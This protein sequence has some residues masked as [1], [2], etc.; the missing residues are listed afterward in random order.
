MNQSTIKYVLGLDLGIASIGWS[1]MI[2][3]ETGQLTRIE[4][5]GIR[6][7]S[8]LEDGKSGK[9]ANEIRRTKRG[10]RRLRRRKHL[11]LQ[12]TKN[13]FSSSLLPDFE[14]F[15]KIDF[16][17]YL[18]PYEI[19]IKGLTEPL[20]KE[21]LSIA[22]YHYMKYR[23]FKSNR[24][25]EDKKNDGVLIKQF[26]DVEN[27]LKENNATITQL[28]YKQ[29]LEARAPE[30]RIHNVDNAGSL[31]NK[32]EQTKSIR[33]KDDKY[34]FSATR[35]MYL[36]EINL[37]LDHQ[38]SCGLI[39]TSFKEQYL[40]IFNRQRSFSMGPGKGSPYAAPE[41]MSLIS[42]MIGVCT[43]DQLPR[44][45]KASFSSESFVLLSFLN[46]L[47]FK[48]K[49][50][51]NYRG[52]TEK[53]I[54]SIYNFALKT[55]ALT[56]KNIFN[57]IN[58][59]VYRIKGLEFSKKQYVSILKAYKK[60]NKIN[61]PSL[62]E[63]QYENFQ[64]DVKNELF[65]SKIVSLSHYHSERKILE[66]YAK[67][68]SSSE[69]EINT[70]IQDTSNFDIIN[71]ILL[72]FKVDQEI[73]NACLKKGISN[74]VA[75][76]IITLPSIDK[77]INLSIDLCKK[78][79][80]HLLENQGYD[81]AMDLVGHNHSNINSSIEK[82]SYLP[83]INEC[84]EKMN[85]SL[86]NVNVRHTLV[87]MRKLINEIIKN[88][89]YIHEIHIEFARE[90][91]KN[92]QDRLDIKN[93]QLENQTDN[94]HL[95]LE[96][97]NKYPHFFHSLNNIK[98]ETLLKYKLYREQNYKCAYSNRPISENELFDSSATQIDH[99]MPYSRTFE[100]RSFNKV[101]VFTS[102]NQVK[103]NRLPYE[104]FKDEKWQKILDFLNDPAVRISAKKKEIILLKEIDDNEWLERNLYDTKYMSVLAK[105]I[106]DAFL[107]PEKCRAI[108]GA[109]TSK[110]KYSYGLTNLTHSFIS[111]NY[112]RFEHF[113]IQSYNFSS[114]EISFIIKD[115]LDK[116]HTILV[117]K[118]KNPDKKILSH[119]ETT[120]NDALQYFLYNQDALIHHVG[121][122]LDESIDFDKL[123]EQIAI[124]KSKA[125]DPNQSLELEYL[126]TILGNIKNQLITITNTKDRS[127]H[128]HHALD[129]TI[130]ACVD[131]K[132]I[133]RIQNYEKM[134]EVL[135]DETTGE[136][137]ST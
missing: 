15:E 116:T 91:A 124:K 7:F 68:H 96:L 2:K 30:R 66:K 44:A 72:Q 100:N 48:E 99:I 77:T 117:S 28:L 80:P 73:I 122:G 108:T 65:S 25:V 123:I 41:G 103:K 133:Y 6:I 129:A 130:I 111:N 34:N 104:A 82:T 10:Q 47:Q 59:P 79:I 32:K 92:F 64:Q 21:E 127:N 11:R 23:G 69:E 45:P 128:L 110:I 46:N 94:I 76:A 118:I 134:K 70:F 38:I 135:Y 40:Q 1:L 33:N 53:E 113:Y 87:E 60:K 131:D 58:I 8:P 95:K 36:K 112:R 51:S 37:L 16:K 24:K 105:K 26:E 3:D 9:L 56:Y 14:K 31:Y 120:L 89:G 39:N 88:Y 126:I 63:E 17:S 97:I 4:N 12:D 85:E 98:G 27:Q 42:K 43:F 114:N 71:E 18:N 54:Q 29:F 67:E 107:K 84:V 137:L 101:L 136:E 52:L 90:L 81:K 13:L 50:E 121:D 55:S 125:N 22:L 115:N 19:K 49:Q 35:D 78:L 106:I 109:I 61:T 132:M 20:T 74:H 93:Q 119:D 102:Y 83:D 75:Q 86:T 62:N 5:L 57:T